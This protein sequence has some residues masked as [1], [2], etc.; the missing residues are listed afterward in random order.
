MSK[1]SEPTSDHCTLSVN[2]G[3]VGNLTLFVIMTSGLAFTLFY[4]F[5]SIFLFLPFKWKYLPSKYHCEFHSF[6]TVW[7]KVP[8]WLRINFIKLAELIHWKFLGWTT[9]SMF[10][11]MVMS[12]WSLWVD[13]SQLSYIIMESSPI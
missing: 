13:L 12:L 4:L 1:Y 5:F 9:S 6:T 7:K 2:H 10:C 3:D 8:L 11:V